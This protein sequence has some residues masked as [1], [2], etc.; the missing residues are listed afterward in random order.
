MFCFFRFGDGDDPAVYSYQEG[1]KERNFPRDYEHLSEFILAVSEEHAKY[2]AEVAR[3][4]TE[5]AKQDPARAR[6]MAAEARQR[7]DYP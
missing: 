7:G 5:M 1:M 2:R 6:K 3:C 4:I